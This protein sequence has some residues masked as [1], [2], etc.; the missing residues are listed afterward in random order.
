MQKN[1]KN[2][3]LGITIGSDFEWFLKKRGQFFPAIGLVKGTK[4]NP[5]PISNK[6]HYLQVDNVLVEGNIPPAK[7]NQEDKFVSD[8]KYVLNYVDNMFKDTPFT[9][10]IVTSAEF[11][12]ESLNS[13]EAM[14]FGCEVSYNAWTGKVNP[15][16]S[17]DTNLRTSSFHIHIGYE[18]PTPEKSRQIVRAMDLLLGLES[19]FKDSD[20]NR[21][22][23]YGKAGEMRYTKYGF[24][25]RT[26]GSFILK[27]E[28][29]MKWAFQTAI[30]AVK[31]GLNNN[32]MDKEIVKSINTHDKVLAKQL[33]DK[34][35][36]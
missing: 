9:T 29:N 13:P 15:S 34:Y 32:V 36:V 2:E 8:I 20:T 17:S 22:K 31:Y 28:D 30:K 26:M 33:I 4:S 16:P 11:D 14:E 35:K 25:Y 27:N 10:E 21:R 23:M 5:F 1:I 19:L 3:D 6:G 12:D 18:N 24:E 7:D